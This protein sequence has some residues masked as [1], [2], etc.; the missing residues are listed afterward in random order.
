MS[1]QARGTT[2]L[3]L[4]RG[5]LTCR[6]SSV[7]GGTVVFRGNLWSVVCPEEEGQ[8]PGRVSSFFLDQRSICSALCG[9]ST[10]CNSPF[11]A[12][13]LQSRVRHLR[14]RRSPLV[15]A[16]DSPPGLSDTAASVGSHEVT[17]PPRPRRASLSCQWMSTRVRR[18]GG[19]FS[20][21]GSSAR[22]AAFMQLSQ[23]L[24]S[25]RHSLPSRTSR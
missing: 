5:V 3:R 12:Q 23:L 21:S 4:A 8:L 7:K 10:C 25:L 11:L 1:W 18:T 22:L 2:Q 13:T 17:T 24:I 9:L 6:S 15:V 16:V 14:A 19:R 20:L